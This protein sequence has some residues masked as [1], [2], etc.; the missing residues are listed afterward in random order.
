MLLS[1]CN[2]GSNNPVSSGFPA[3]SGYKIN[4]TSA[5]NTVTAGAT[6]VITAQIIEPD[7]SPVRDDQDVVFSSSI[8]GSFSD[9][10]VKTKNGS[11]T[12]TYTAGDT[13]MQLD[14][15]SASC[16]GAIATIQIMVLP[17]TF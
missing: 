6:S 15:I 7:G 4:L 13:P 9:S 17:Q 12:V 11:V 16:N 1:G 10:P 2:A 8:G 14:S 5:V 3:G